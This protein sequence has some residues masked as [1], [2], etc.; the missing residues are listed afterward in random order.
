MSTLPNKQTRFLTVQN[1]STHLKLHHPLSCLIIYNMQIAAK[2][3]VANG[4]RCNSLHIDS[5]KIGHII[6]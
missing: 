4:Y 3:P 6:E 1:H 2:R 5:T